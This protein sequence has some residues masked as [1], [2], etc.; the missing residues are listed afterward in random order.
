MKSINDIILEGKAGEVKKLYM[1]AIL[2][3]FG[4]WKEYKAYDDLFSS[5]TK[6]EL[7]KCQDL[8]DFLDKCDDDN[9]KRIRFSTIKE[10]FNILNKMADYVLNTNSKEFGVHDKK[11]WKEIKEYI[12]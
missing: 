11:T 4:M 12:N 8:Y 9:N 6:D 1:L 10:Y 5:F 2:I 7:E 3:L